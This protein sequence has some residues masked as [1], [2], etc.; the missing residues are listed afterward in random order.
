MSKKHLER[1]NE[2]FEGNELGRFFFGS[3]Q[4]FDLSEIN[5]LY[6]SVDTVRQL[7]K[8][9][10]DPVFVEKLDLTM[11]QDGFHVRIVELNGY[12]FVLKRGG[13]SGYKY[14][15]QNN[16]WGLTVLVKH[17]KTKSECSGS[18]LKIEVSPKLI[19]E[20]SGESL[21]LLMD[22]IADLIALDSNYQRHAVAPHLAIDFQGWEPPAG[23]DQKLTCRSRRVAL[24]NGI[25]QLQLDTDI[26]SVYGRGQSFTFGAANSL[27]MALYNKSEEA[28]SS[29]KLDYFKHCWSRKKDSSENPVYDP[30]K[31]V[32][33]LE[34]RFHHSVIRQFSDMNVSAPVDERDEEGNVTKYSDLD[35]NRLNSYESLIPHLGG[36]WA[37]ALNNFRYDLNSRYIHPVWTVFMTESGFDQFQH[38]F[39]YR[40]KYKTAGLGNE[41]NIAI[42]LGN[43]I[44]IFA[45]NKISAGKAHHFIKKSGIYN[46]ILSYFRSR[47]MDRA[48]VFRFIENGLIQRRL[49]SKLAA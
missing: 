9:H 29:D 22:N 20:H 10:L 24:R 25:S 14:I 43:M 2:L 35:I 16:E 5:I 37:Y 26:C 46:D 19:S 36:L 31:P 40:R 30:D 12:E 11:E 3:N 21:N 34:L 15:L 47:G 4:S 18:H 48:D 44:S 17:Q 38:D 13:A 45:R 33:R 39:V 42:A 41:K 8:M 32:W 28:K 6:T 27:Q 7:Y 23:F 1:F 49:T